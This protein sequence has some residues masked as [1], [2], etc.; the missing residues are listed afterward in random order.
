MIFGLSDDFGFLFP[1]G[2]VLLI[3][4]YET[5]DDLSAVLHWLRPGDS[6]MMVDS[7]SGIALDCRV[8]LVNGVC[9][10]VALLNSR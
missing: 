1:L 4:W 8:E 9:M 5:N 7:A 10:V 3:V 6:P 2:S